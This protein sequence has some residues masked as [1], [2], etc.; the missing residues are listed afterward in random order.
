VNCKVNPAVENCLVDF[1]LED[2]LLIEGEERCA[3]VRITRGRDDRAV[4]C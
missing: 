2:S 3:L 1:F 4:Y